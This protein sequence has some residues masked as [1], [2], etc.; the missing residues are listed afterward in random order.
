MYPKSASNWCL[1]YKCSSYYLYL[2]MVGFIKPL[3]QT[4][5]ARCISKSKRD[6]EQSRDLGARLKNFISMSK[7]Q[8]G[9][10]SISAL[11]IRVFCRRC[12]KASLA[13]MCWEQHVLPWVLVWRIITAGVCCQSNL[14]PLGEPV[15]QSSKTTAGVIAKTCHIYFML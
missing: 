8:R 13:R 4:D 1:V 7:C 5:L 10:M 9:G 11:R 2:C 14:S 12:F 15:L 6:K 3:G